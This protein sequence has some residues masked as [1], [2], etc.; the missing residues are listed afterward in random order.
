M[1]LARIRA[2]LILWSLAIVAAVASTGAVAQSS[3]FT[4]ETLY[5]FNGKNGSGPGSA[6]T[7]GPEGVLYGTANGGV[8]GSGVAFSISQMGNF[9][10]LYTFTGG[11]DG[12]SPTSLT[13][14]QG[15]LYGATGGGVSGNGTAFALSL[16]GTLQTI[17]NYT[18]A[19]PDG[20]QPGPLVLLPNNTFL[21]TSGIGGN[22]GWGVVYQMTPVGAVQGLY[23]FSYGGLEE[24]YP[25]GVIL[26]TDGNYYGTTLGINA[27]NAGSGQA[28]AIWQLTPTGVLTT[29]HV[30]G[31]SDGAQPLGPPVQA[32]D[33]YFYGTA[34]SGGASGEGVIYR[35]SA[36]GDY[37]VLYSFTGGVDG[38]S[39]RASLIVGKDGNLYGSTYL[40]GSSGFGTLF[41]VTT[42][43]VL[44]T[45][46]SFTGKVDGSFV[47]APLV[48]T[49]A[50]T[51]FGVTDT[52]GAHGLGTIFKLT[53]H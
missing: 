27:P 44:T 13:L 30:F 32:P 18:F 22:N 50:G 14:A 51:F 11:A 53:I 17:H 39:P 37:S 40:G 4:L 29:L 45:L 26:G 34:S 9:N 8:Y 41:R 47:E 46:H 31:W 52:G 23:S 12:G 10:L 33:G 3:R 19:G 20:A 25:V 49:Q 7:L 28:G 15:A 1:T 43:G 16:D 5:P 2:R 21:G 36:A 48:E 24:S 42:A 35:V 38:G 6:L